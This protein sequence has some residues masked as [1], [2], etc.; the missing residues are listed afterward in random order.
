MTST[1]KNFLNYRALLIFLITFNIWHATKRGIWD[2]ISIINSLH[3]S[4]KST[5]EFQPLDSSLKASDRPYD[6][7]YVY[8]MSYDPLLI[9]RHYLGAIDHPVYRYQRILLPLLAHFAAF[10]YVH[11]YPYLLLVIN[12][13]AYLAGGWAAWKLIKW[14]H[15][16]PWL[17]L[18]YFANTGLL[19][20]TFA[21]LTEPLGMCLALWGIFFWQKR[22]RRIA[23][24]FFAISILA[25]ETFLVIP[26]SILLWDFLKGIQPI[27]KI[28]IQSLF[29][30]GPF[31]LW[32]GYLHWRLAGETAF[33]LPPEAPAS[34]GWGRFSLPF[35]GLWQETRFGL[36]HLTTHSNVKLTVSLSMVTASCAIFSLWGFFLKR[37]FWGI[38]T[39][40]QALFVICLRGD[41][42][43]YHVSSA[44]VVIPLFFF[45][46]AWCADSMGKSESILNK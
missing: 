42:W 37:S 24:I 39:A 16:T 45:M 38:I 44:R 20:S 29:I 34:F 8:A 43:N 19:Y 40:I 12:I 32:F 14:N 35:V 10:N 21:T 18:G 6:G 23:S 13:G 30:V 17:L 2:P 33:F 25:R 5:Q 4:Q 27:R 11:L 7:Q 28:V 9:S 22:D 46:M 1:M 31:I 41:I 36:K 3:L 15:W 26:M